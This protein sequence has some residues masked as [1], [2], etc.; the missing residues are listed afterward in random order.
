MSNEERPT[1]PADLYDEEYYTRCEGYEEFAGKGELGHSRRLEAALTLANIEPGMWV[2][3]LG[4]GRGEVLVQC[5]G[6]G[7]RAWGVDYA[8]AAARIVQATVDQLQGEL[9]ERIGAQVGNVKTLP[10][11]DSTFDRVFMLDLVE[12]LYPW[13]LE[14]ALAEAQRVLRYNGQLVVHTM[15]NRWYYQFGYP[16][17]RLLNRLR[18]KR[19]P[20]NPRARFQYHLDAHVNEQDIWGLSASL[21]RAG[22]VPRVWVDN[23]H[24]ESLGRGRIAR[25]VN[26]IVRLPGFRLFLCNDLLAIA[27]KRPD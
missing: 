16:V 1:V 19:L 6:Q 5:A 12:H 14:L 13:E 2:L 17:W 26:G 18:G 10:F 11:A 3:D 15:P 23:L 24:P 20:R 27:A 8:P 22:F 4:C 25:M 7:A 21:R 9:R